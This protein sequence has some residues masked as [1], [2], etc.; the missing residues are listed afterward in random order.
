MYETMEIVLAGLP[1]KHLIYGFIVKLGTC[2]WIGFKVCAFVPHRSEVKFNMFITMDGFSRI[3]G[4][5]LGI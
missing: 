5:V 2:K 3:T 1:K 4:E